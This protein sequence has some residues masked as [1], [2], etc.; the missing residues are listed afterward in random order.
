MKT[1][2][3]KG[4]LLL[5]LAIFVTSCCTTHYVEYKSVIYEPVYKSANEVRQGV[6]MSSPRSIKNSGKI[7]SYGNYILIGE[8]NEGIHIVDNSNPASPV[9]KSFI[10]IPGNGDMAI[11]NGILFA[12][13]YI[14]LV[15]IDISNPNQ[16][17]LIKR[18]ENIFPYSL[19]SEQM[20]DYDPSKGIVVDVI[21]KDTIIKYSYKD[22]GDSYGVAMDA[23]GPRESGGF[24]SNKSGG[25]ITGIGGSM[26]RLTISSDYLYSVDRSDLQVFDISNVRNPRVFN[27]VNIG[28]DIETIFPFK[29]K[30][31]IGSMTGMFIYDISN[32]S[33]PR[34]LSQFS[35]ARACDPVVADDN[36]AYVTLRSGTA[37]GGNQNQLDVID[38]KDITRPKLIKSY[39]MQQPAGLGLDKNVLFVCDG[40]AGLKVYDVNKP[41][42]L[43]LIDWQSD[44]KTYDVI[45]LGYSLLMIGEDGFYQYDYTDP[46]N[47]KLLSKIPVVK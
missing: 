25:S 36:Y 2:L 10:S 35:H 33:S 31:F 40:P 29:D 11:R 43:Q 18:I 44:M 23:G 45:P 47:L 32:S 7:Y 3:I 26:A 38:I 39:P 17:E 8:R 9:V 42:D 19:N 5:F 21:E 46:K 20:W 28:W 12:D 27:K 13:S 34:L 24:N 4:T 30:L 16:A 37:C 1:N 14:D 41:E 6:K 15:A 22:C